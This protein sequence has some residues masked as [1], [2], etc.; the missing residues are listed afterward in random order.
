MNSARPIVSAVI[1]TRNR[2]RFIGDCVKG[3]LNQYADRMTYEILVINNGSTDGTR[4]VLQPFVERGDVRVVDEPVAG[5][6]RARN[7]GWVAARGDFVGYIDDDAVAEPTWISSVL[8]V[9]QSVQPMPSWI[10]GPIQLNWETERPGWVDDELAVPLGY[11][12]W[13]DS[14]RQLIK[15][16]R[17]GGGNS[18]FPRTVLSE[19]G[20]FDERLGRGASGLLSGEETQLQYRVEQVGGVLYYHP[21]MCIH[22][23]VGRERTKPQWFYRRY[24]WGGV[25]D[26]I[27]SRTLDGR[28]V[29]SDNEEMGRQ[30]ESGSRI[31]R[32][33]KN[34]AF[35]AG[36]GRSSCR[37]IH[38]RIYM[39]Y[40]LGRLYGITYWKR[41][42]LNDDSH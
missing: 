23:F 34:A 20:G 15:G 37:V 3:L 25:T 10:G 32:L 40:V 33:V 12:Y 1:C 42:G 8:E 5:L 30:S 16:E 2:E 38:A 18:V 7:T 26:Y 36:L 28:P 29:G 9:V 35:S 14:P 31:A 17:L 19:L 13:G 22:H 24:F 11:L 41:S 27:M 21:G 39:A 6:S 4:S